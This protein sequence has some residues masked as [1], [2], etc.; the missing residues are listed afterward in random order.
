MRSETPTIIPD[1]VKQIEPNTFKSPGLESIIFGPKSI[2][3]TLKLKTISIPDG[4]KKLEPRTFVSSGLES[5]TF[6][7]R[8]KLKEIS[9]NAFETSTGN[10]SK[11]VRIAIPNEVKKI[12]PKTFK[13]SVLESIT[14]GPKSKLDEIGASAFELAKNLIRINIPK[15]VTAIGNFTFSKS[16][17]RFV[18]FD[19]DSQLTEIGGSTFK[20]STNL[21]RITIPQ[22]VTSIQKSAFEAL[23]SLRLVI[24]VPNSRLKVIGE[25][26]FKG[27]KRVKRMTIPANVETIKDSAFENTGISTLTFE[28]DSH[29]E[30]IKARAFYS[31]KELKKVHI[32]ERV[33]R[34]GV[35]AF[36]QSNLKE[37]TFASNS[38]LKTFAKGA[39]AGTN[40]GNVTIPE[41][42][43][44]IGEEAF[45]YAGLESVIFEEGSTIQNI[46]AKAFANNPKLDT[47]NIPEGVTIASDAFEKTGC[48][49]S[50]IFAAGVTIVN[51]RPVGRTVGRTR[52]PSQ[53]PTGRGSCNSQ[54][55]ALRRPV[56]TSCSRST[57]PGELA[58]DGDLNT[59]WRC[60]GSSNPYIVVDLR[61]VQ[62]V[63]KVRLVWGQ[64]FAKQFVIT[65]Y[66]QESM[67]WKDI[68]RDTNGQGGVQTFTTNV[69]TKFITVGVEN[70]NG[71]SVSLQELEVCR[72]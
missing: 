13:G 43:G 47:I 50:S 22:G 49:D 57:S 38:I 31:T 14:F 71:G 63:Q 60:D 17:L 36:R 42:V 33:T 25:F 5:I 21:E 67:T 34:I 37:L 35:N 11:L 4:V 19:P 30:E 23:A 1:G 52:F 9:F 45:Q 61:A 55:L 28:S 48:D 8:S 62:M 44:T 53:G 7:P 26:A 6:G 51:C 56:D 66:D 12:K 65:W 70:L 16:G 18:T 10:T 58:V 2:R 29:L 69:S 39:F 27:S 64:E 54:N 40:L 3:G 15:S 46:G 72:S 59:Q 32:P 68:F 24:F 41:S 20:G